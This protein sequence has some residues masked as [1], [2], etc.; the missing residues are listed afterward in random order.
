MRHPKR[1]PQ[2]IKTV[3]KTIKYNQ[4]IEH[5]EEEKACWDPVEDKYERLPLF[6]KLSFILTAVCIAIY[7]AACASESFADFFNIHI[8]SIFRW[9]FAKITNIFVFSIA[10]LIIILIPIIMFII[11][12]YLLKFRCK[13]PKASL[14]SSLCL[15]S[16]AALMLSAFI[17]TFATGYRGSS[18]ASKLSIERE[19]VSADDLYASAEYLIQQINDLSEH[20]NYDNEDF[21][22]MPYSF[23][24]MNDLLLDAYKEYSQDKDF[25]ITYKTRLKPVALSEA[26]SYTHITGV[27]SFFTGEANINAAFPDYTI[28]YTAAHELAHQ[29][30]I[31]RE[32][33]ANMIAFLVCIES[34]DTYIRYCAYLNMYEYVANALYKAD[35]DLYYDAALQLSEKV[36][37]EQSAYSSFFDKYEDSS[38]STVSGAVNDVYLKSQG[39]EGRKSYGMVVD[40]TIAYLKSENLIKN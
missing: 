29:R 6:C 13:T 16:V 9:C 4:Y 32:D 3:Q 27:Y 22:V 14:M 31:A 38:A 2:S 23:D 40:I 15:L 19:D 30:G 12:W 25:I 36:R 28:P 39:T 10:E 1:T 18:L 26:M 21:S 8:S 7:I 24:K 34:D 37:K 17:L 35:K 11:L 20:I 33:E 5:S